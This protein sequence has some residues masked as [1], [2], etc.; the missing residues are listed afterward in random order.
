MKRRLVLLLAWE[1]LLHIRV[2]SD[3][4]C[5]QLENLIQLDLAKKGAVSLKA[6]IVKQRFQQSL[7]L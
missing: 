4:P 3:T 6:L 2:P 5:K 1:T 7:R